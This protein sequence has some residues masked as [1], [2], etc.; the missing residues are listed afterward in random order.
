MII[1]YCDCDIKMKL[2]GLEEAEKLLNRARN[3]FSEIGRNLS[4]EME[5]PCL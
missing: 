2:G 3:C 4:V 1:D 5:G